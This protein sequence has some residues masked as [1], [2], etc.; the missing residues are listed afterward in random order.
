MTGAQLYAQYAW[1]HL[2]EGVSV[3]AWED[4]DEAERIVWAKLAD[5]IGK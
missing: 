4:L 5:W 2:Q 3:D 1:L